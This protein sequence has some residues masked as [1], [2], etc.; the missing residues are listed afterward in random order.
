MIIGERISVRD[1]TG[2]PKYT[3]NMSMAELYSSCLDCSHQQGHLDRCKRCG[4]SLL[5]GYSH[6]KIHIREIRENE[7]GLAMVLMI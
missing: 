7:T 5:P 3:I 4:W 6:S 1:Y 2:I